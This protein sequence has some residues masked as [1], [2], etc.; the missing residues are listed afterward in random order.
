MLRTLAQI[1]LSAPRVFLSACCKARF[2]AHGGA[3][4]KKR[5][6]AA[7][8]EEQPNAKITSARVL[9]LLL[10]VY[11]DVARMLCAAGWRLPSG[12]IAA[13]ACAGVSSSS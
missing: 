6:A 4:A 7:A 5:K 8:T 2:A 11:C 9:S 3:L 10:G 1:I 12:S 13:S